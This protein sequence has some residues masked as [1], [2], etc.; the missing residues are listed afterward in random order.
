M[1][2]KLLNQ[3]IGEKKSQGSDFPPCYSA[4]TSLDKD[5]VQAKTVI[6]FGAPRGG[7][8][9]IA[10]VAMKCGLF[11]GDDLPINCED[12]DFNIRQLKLRNLP[13]APTIRNT[14]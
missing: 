5:K 6:I 9:M 14:I 1:K 3:L 8:T 11:L 7:T 10:G 2:T 4:Y 13:V 12:P